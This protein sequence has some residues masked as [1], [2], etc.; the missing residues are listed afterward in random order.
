MEGE[1]VA[2]DVS[3]ASYSA[4]GEIGRTGRL[5]FESIT[6]EDGALSVGLFPCSL[7]DCPEGGNFD[8]II[9]AI[10]VLPT[11]LPILTCPRDLICTVKGPGE[12]FGVWTSGDGVEV[13]GYQVFRNGVEIATLPAGATEFNDAGS[14]SRVVTYE[15]VPLSDDPE[16]FCPSLRMRCTTVHPDC[17]FDVP[18]RINMGGDQAVDSQ[19]RL[20][21]GD[22]PCALLPV[23]DPLG[24]RPLPDVGIAG[25]NQ[26][27]CNW[28]AP[29]AESFEK[30]DLDADHPG[31]RHIFSTIRWDFGGDG[32]DDF[33]VEIP[34]DIDGIDNGLVDVNL[35]FNECGIGP[36]RHFRVSI[37]DEIVDDDV[38][39]ADYDD[40]PGAGKLGRLTFPDIDVSDEVVRIGFLPCLDCPGGLDPNAIVNAIEILPSSGVRREICDNEVDDDD[41]GAVDCDDTDCTNNA[42]CLPESI[43]DDGEDN[44]NDG[45]TDCLD[46]DC[47]AIKGACPDG[48]RFVRGDSNSS[49]IVDLTDGVVTLN[50]LFTGGPPPAC[51]DAADTDGN[52]QLVISDAVIVFSYLFT[53]GPA[54]VVP[55][56]SATSYAPEDCGLDPD[57]DALLG[58][59]IPATKCQ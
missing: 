8:P 23:E 47:R 29:N 32:I 57:D 45:L 50:F 1:I 25:G 35:Y 9:D 17:P 18:V 3:S 41:D 13:T 58:C 56:P 46:P 51:R 7:F 27:I 4:S 36:G 42:S 59:E 5:V 6:V 39:A 54:P 48:V 16:F 43:C 30:Y 12:V 34:I 19:G 37:Q 15:V 2:D 11:D 28:C 22:R 20:W 26:A 40:V 24:I 55:G 31:D 21:F 33:F 52:N 49:G 14:C 44:D 53:G 10:E 38:S